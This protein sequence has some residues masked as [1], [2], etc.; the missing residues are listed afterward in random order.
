MQQP[1]RQDNLSYKDLYLT[2]K[3][4]AHEDCFINEFEHNDI[5]EDLV[6]DLV[7][8]KLIFI[9]SDERIMLTASGEKILQH[10]SFCVELYKF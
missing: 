3:M 4:F 1:K 2:L 9:T 5:F 7:S 8:Y 6:W 10:L